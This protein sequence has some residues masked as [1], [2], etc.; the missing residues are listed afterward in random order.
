MC[1]ELDDEVI[2]ELAMGRGRGTKEEGHVLECCECQER[3]RQ[4]HEWISAFRQAFAARQQWKVRPV[5]TKPVKK[6]RSVALN[7]LF[8]KSAG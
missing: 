6:D 3:L 7:Y 8:F 5:R 2:E 1:V 4:S